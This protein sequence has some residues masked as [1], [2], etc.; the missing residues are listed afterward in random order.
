LVKLK[1]SL[2]LLN[3]A[4]E[5]TSREIRMLVKSQEN[6]APSLSTITIAI[7]LHPERYH[8]GKSK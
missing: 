3:L 6:V 7:E 4:T 2:G 8:R 1:I 5:F